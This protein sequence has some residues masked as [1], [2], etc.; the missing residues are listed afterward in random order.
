[1]TGCL[2]AWQKAARYNALAAANRVFTPELDLRCTEVAQT[3]QLVEE[4]H[5]TGWDDPRMPTL[6]GARRRGYSAAGFHLFAD[7]WRDQ[8]RLTN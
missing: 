1:M 5:V 8:E 7:H 3:T 2:S 4:K 6:V